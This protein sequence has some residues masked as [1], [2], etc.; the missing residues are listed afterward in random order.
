[1]HESVFYFDLRKVYMSKIKKFISDMKKELDKIRWC[2]GKN[3]LKNVIVTILF[4]I[5]FVYLFKRRH[6]ALYHFPVILL[7]LLA[8]CIAVILESL[9]KHIKGKSTAPRGCQQKTL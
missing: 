3:L 5:F 6:G 4:I 9:Y 1:M 7:C 8:E 2:K